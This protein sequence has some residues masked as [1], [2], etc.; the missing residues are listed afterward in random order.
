LALTDRVAEGTG[1]RTADAADAFEHALCPREEVVEHRA[2][3]ALPPLVALPGSEPR[4]TLFELEEG[5]DAKQTLTRRRV[6]DG[7]GSLPQPASGVAPTSDR[8]S[9]GKGNEDVV[10]RNLS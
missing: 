9:L 3:D 4:P 6:L 2:R 7:D 5:A 8:Q 10:V 1:D